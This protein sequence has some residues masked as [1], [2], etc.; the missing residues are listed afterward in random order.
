MQL[1]SVPA[2]NYDRVGTQRLLND[3]AIDL[4][5]HDAQLESMVRT[6][7]TVGSGWGEWFDRTSHTLLAGRDAYVALNPQDGELAARLG[8]ELIDFTQNGGR[9]ASAQ[10]RGTSL[11]RGWD[12]AL[13]STISVVQEAVNRLY[14]SNPTP[15]APPVTPPAPPVTPPSN[16]GSGEVIRDAA[17]AAKLVRRSLET[18][19]QLPTEDTGTAGTKDA[20]IAAYNLNMDAQKLIEPYFNAGDEFVTSQLRSADA[21]LEDA[22]WQLAKKPSP[23]GRFNGVD[24]PGAQR[25]TDAAAVTLEKLVS[26]LSSGA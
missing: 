9:I 24:I 6:G 3:L 19:R 21:S 16:G 4:S 20:R 17:Q 11:G 26:A 23:D 7:N 22:N 10:D 18:I 5:R 15:P 1:T 8:T 25:D 2:A 13:D 12:D 14:G